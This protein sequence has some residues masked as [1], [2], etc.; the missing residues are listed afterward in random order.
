MLASL[1]NIWAV[2]S[3]FLQFLRVK[4]GGKYLILSDTKRVKIVILHK[5]RF[6]EKTCKKVSCNK[7]GF[8]QAIANLAFNSKC[9]I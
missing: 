9:F 3:I 7:T 1:K 5:K 2:S 6:Q 8:H 4:K